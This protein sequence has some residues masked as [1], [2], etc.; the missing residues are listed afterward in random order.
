MRCTKPLVLAA[1]LL[2]AGCTL[3][4]L[5]SNANQEANRL[6]GNWTGYDGEQMVVRQ[7]ARRDCLERAINPGINRLLAEGRIVDATKVW[8]ANYPPVTYFNVFDEAQREGILKTLSKMPAC[9]WPKDVQLGKPS[10][11]PAQ[12]GPFMLVPTS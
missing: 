4:Q 9:T 12:L 8:Q 11:A 5:G 2:A 1:A 3:P 6:W 10:A 7:Q